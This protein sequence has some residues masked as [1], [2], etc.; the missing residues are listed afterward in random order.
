VL[1][2]PDIFTRSRQRLDQVTG[3]LSETLAEIEAWRAV[4]L[5]ADYPPEEQGGRA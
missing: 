1:R 5:A 4:G 3:K 2:R